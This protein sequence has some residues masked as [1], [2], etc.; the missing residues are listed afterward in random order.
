MLPRPPSRRLSHLPLI[1]LHVKLQLPVKAAYQR[2]GSSKLCFT[3]KVCQ[4]FDVS[5]THV[6]PD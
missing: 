2:T 4:V 3:T 1:T 5:W 6:K